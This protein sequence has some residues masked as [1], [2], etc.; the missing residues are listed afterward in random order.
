MPLRLLGLLPAAQ[1]SPPSLLPGAALWAACF[2]GFGVAL[3]VG[4]LWAARRRPR[5]ARLDAAAAPAIPPR[6]LAARQLDALLAG[7]LR[8]HRVVLLGEERT[9]CIACLDAAV[10]PVELVAAVE[11]LAVVAGPPIALVVAAPGRLE[12]PIGSEPAATLAA[13]VAGRFPL[14]VVDGPADWAPLA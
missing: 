5:P 8:Q 3:A 13:E 7:P 12:A 1:V 14:W 9:G 11:R 10:L 6:R 4:L 2:A